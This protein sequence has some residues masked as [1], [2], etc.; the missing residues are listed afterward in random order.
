MRQFT[1]EELEDWIESGATWRPL[2]VSAN[3]TVIDLLTCYGEPVDRVRS[4]APAVIEYVRTHR[5]D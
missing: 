1:V 4:D 2:E 5:D 3:H